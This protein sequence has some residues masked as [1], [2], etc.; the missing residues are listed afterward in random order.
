MKLKIRTVIYIH[1]GKE[2]KCGRSYFLC[3]YWMEADLNASGMYKR[4]GVYAD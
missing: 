2:N 4:G 3:F 1:I